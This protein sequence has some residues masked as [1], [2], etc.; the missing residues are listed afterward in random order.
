MSPGRT[1]FTIR[2]IA[3]SSVG[4]PA[5]FKARTAGRA[6]SLRKAA[7]R[8]V[9]GGSVCLVHLGHRVR[10]QD[11]DGRL[12]RSAA[13]TRVLRPVPG[14][15]WCCGLCKARRRAGV[16]ARTRATGARRTWG[17]AGARGTTGGRRPRVS[18]GRTMARA[19]PRCAAAKPPLPCVGAGPRVAR[20]RGTRPPGSTARTCWR[21][22][23]LR[24][25]PCRIPRRGGRCVGGRRT[26]TRD[27]DG[28]ARGRPTA[29]EGGPGAL[30]GGRGRC[31]SSPCRAS[32]AGPRATCCREGSPG[33]GR[34]R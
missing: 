20:A 22:S 33:R 4:P 29:Y 12:L 30:A 23:A 27:G 3:G 2:C 24:R 8:V 5:P 19:R 17:P 6:A 15:A 14:E 34:R 10:H 26:A 9:L 11:L 21:P 28:G 32:S 1:A 25:I 31:A 7:R 16:R 13:V 18:R